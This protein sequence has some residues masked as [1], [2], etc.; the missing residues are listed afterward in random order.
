MRQLLTDLAWDYRSM[1]SHKRT[2]SDKPIEA[3]RMASGLWAMAKRI[4]QFGIGQIHF[5]RVKDSGLVQLIDR[6]AELCAELSM[7][8]A[9]PKPRQMAKTP[10]QPKDVL[11]G[12]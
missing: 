8:V 5:T 9:P 1:R 2:A 4:E 11:K 6:A 12:Q 10:I 7:D 3:L